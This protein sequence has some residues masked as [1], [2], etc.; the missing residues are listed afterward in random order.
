MESAEVIF[1]AVFFGWMLA[2]L[3]GIILEDLK[4]E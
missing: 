1:L 3:V 2:V 4:D